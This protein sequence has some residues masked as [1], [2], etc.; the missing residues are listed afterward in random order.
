[1]LFDILVLIAGLV[2]LVVAGDL[3]VRG[4]VALAERL[5]IPP[6]IIGLTIVAFGTS[7]PELMVSVRAALDNAS[8]IA[9]GNVVGSNIANI[10]LVLG[11]PSLF[12]ASDCCAEG[13]KRATVAMLLATAL[14][15][16]LAFTGPLTIWHGA[17]LLTGLALFI[18]QSAHTARRQSQSELETV[19]GVE[20]VPQKLWVTLAFILAGLIGLP[21][22]AGWTVDAATAIARVIGISETV[23]GLSIV[24][25]GTSL[26]EL[27]TTLVAALRGQGAVGVGN[28]IG[29]NVFNL[30]SILG[31]TALI[32]DLPVPAEILNFDLW[33]MLA[34]A[35]LLVPFVFLMKPIGK[36]AGAAFTGLY[37]LYLVIIFVNGASA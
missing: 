28:V 5:G 33:V 13:T 6:L 36:V 35:L 21:L 9:I 18:A 22:A 16:A 15:I 2:G 14:F 7:A 17:V 26:P 24:A 27:A 34:S 4:A 25:I 29:S 3:L 32:A 30:L 10:L 31:I 19:D 12:A 8:G 11:V 23:I 37:V 20:G 1:M